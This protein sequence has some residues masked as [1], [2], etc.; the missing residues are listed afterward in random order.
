MFFVF[1]SIPDRYQTQD[2]LLL[3]YSPDQYKTQKMSDKIV[4]DSPA[5]SKLIPD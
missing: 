2:P 5:A 1:D 4:D 3:A